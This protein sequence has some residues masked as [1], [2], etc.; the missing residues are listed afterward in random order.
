MPALEKLLSSGP[1]PTL[2]HY[3]SLPAFNSIVS[4]RK[5]WATHV[6]YMNDS[7]EIDHA[8]R[9]AME[10]TAQVLGGS[11][12]S[13]A[14][15]ESL[16]HIL[17]GM[18]SGLDLPDRQL[19]FCASS[20]SESGD[21]LSQWR[22]Y[23]PNGLGVSIGFDSAIFERSV[24]DKKQTIGGFSRCI[25]QDA[26]KRDLI[27]EILAD[28]CRE[29]LFTEKLRLDKVVEDMG[30]LQEHVESA[31]EDWG[32]RA[33]P[34]LGNFWA[35]APVIKDEAFSDEREWR[36]VAP[37]VHPRAGDSPTRSNWRFRTN[38]S[39]LV[40]YV[41]LDFSEGGPLHLNEVILS[42][43]PHPERSVHA[44]ELFLAANNVVCDSVRVS[45]IP[46]RNW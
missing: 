8:L 13:G 20:F 46:F 6:R 4:T 28:V 17:K 14:I 19:A 9:Y 44:V 31:I 45:R 35:V 15:L 39:T 41:E 2:Y 3:T 23:C 36:Y 18:L 12:V 16:N 38:G 27:K 43:N 30:R 40:P 29:E 25:Y 33:V 21:S 37:C 11:G 1:P 34:A 5:L 22:G 7:S 42:P 26:E 24:R 32:K 10:F